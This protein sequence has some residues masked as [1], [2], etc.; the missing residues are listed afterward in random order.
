MAVQ[1][2]PLITLL[3]VKFL[4]VSPGIALGMI[5]VAAC[6]GGNVS[7]FFSMLAKGNVALSVTLTAISSLIA[8]LITP[9]SF[10]FCSS[11]FPTLSGEVWAMEISFPELFLNMFL[12]LLLP[13]VAGMWYGAVRPDEAGKIAKILRPLSMV[14]L[15]GFIAVAFYNNRAVFMAEIGSVFWI[16]LLH[17]GLALYAAYLFSRLLRNN[18]SN[19]RTIAIETGIQN[20]GLALVLIFTF[21][22]G[23]KDMALI[24]AWW[25]IWHLISGMVFATVMR[26]IPIKT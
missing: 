25:G 21:F 4:P 10:F 8:F 17:N 12:I 19:S 7:N 3:L 20:S 24:A 1:F 18:E 22:G 16:V 5:L 23:N 14:L 11:L 15:F 26:R 13:L 9:A 2:S 6:P